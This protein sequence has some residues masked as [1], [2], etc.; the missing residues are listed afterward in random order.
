LAHIA[1]DLFQLIFAPDALQKMSKTFWALSMLS[2][3]PWR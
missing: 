2:R 3:V 1:H